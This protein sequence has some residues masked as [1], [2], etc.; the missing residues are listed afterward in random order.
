M[1]NQPRFNQKPKRA[2]PVELQ[3]ISQSKM[4]PT[5]MHDKIKKA[6]TSKI[7]QSEIELP[8]NN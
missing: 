7:N 3:N 4:I 5:G 8:R 1:H 6:I 2:P